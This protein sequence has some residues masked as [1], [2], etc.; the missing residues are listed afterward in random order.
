MDKA[1]RHDLKTDPVIE[2]AEHA[3]SYAG[4]H[5]QQLIRYGAIALAVLLIGGGVW[6]FLENR[7]AERAAA[8]REVF[9]AREGSIAGA[10]ASFGS[11]R[12]FTTQ[13]EKDAAVLKAIENVNAKF[14]GTDEAA[15]ANYYKAITLSDAGKLAE[16]RKVMEEVAKTGGDYGAL[17]KLSVAQALIG[18]GRNAEGEKMLRELLANPTRLVSQEQATIALARALVDTKPDEATKL[19]EPLRTGRASIGRNA[20]A[21]LGDITAK[22]NKK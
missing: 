13:Q 14:A 3:A 22:K 5:R 16:A 12:T 21:V 1:E 19:L 8:V 10:Q 9:S 2:A 15:M 11:I 6:W 17:A 20:I 7:K 18:E 4:S